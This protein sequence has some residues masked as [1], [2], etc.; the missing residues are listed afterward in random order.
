MD[1]DVDN[2]AGGYRTPSSQIWV[3]MH[4]SEPLF[5]KPFPTNRPGTCRSTSDVVALLL[6]APH[7]PAAPVLSHGP[8]QLPSSIL[9]EQ[10]LVLEGAKAR[11]KQG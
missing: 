6:L 10:L 11:E 4:G 3:G 1:I 2:R 8:H 5:A 7:H 9:P